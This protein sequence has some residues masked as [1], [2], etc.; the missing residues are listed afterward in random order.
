MKSV[1]KHDFGQTANIEMQRSSFDRSHG[2]KTAFDAG[3][4]I[5]FYLDEILPG[6][7]VNLKTTALARI[8][9]PYFP[10][11]DNIFMETQ[12]F[13]VPNRLI[14]DNFQK[15][16]GEQTNPG[17]S[18]DYL[19]PRLQAPPVGG[20]LEESVFD[21]MG[22][23]PGVDN[24]QPNALHLRA[25]NLIWNQWY[26]D[27]NLQDS[28][29]VFTG[30]GPDPTTSYEILPRGKRPDYFTSALPWPQKGDAVD[31]PLGT[32]API[33]GTGVPTF[34]VST[35]TN[36]PLDANAGDAQFS[37]TILSG[38]A[39]WN[40]PQ[41]S[42]DLSTATAATINELRQAFQIQRLLERDARGG[43]RYTEIV[44]SHFGVTSP[45]ARLQRAEYL[46]GGRATINFQSVPI[47]EKLSAGGN[48]A[49]DLS[50]YGQTMLQD[51]G[52][53]KSFT[54]HGVLIGFVS[55]RADLTYQ[56][57]LDRMW[58]RQSKYDFYFP[59]LSHIGEQAILNKEIYLRGTGGDDNVF[60]YIP[61]YDEYRFKNSQ[62]TGAMRSSAT[63]SLDPWHLSQD[64]GALPVLGDTF[65]QED[66]PIDR[67][68]TVPTE[69]Q[70]IFDS[71][72]SARFARPLPTYGT[73]G[74]LDRF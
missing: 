52:F 59:A 11:M 5:P 15:F 16:M 44:R 40:D 54:E 12:Y 65:I 56:Q 39:S 41:L 66:P 74:M 26:R 57:G 55:V 8:S 22:I 42:A 71:Y 45:D 3:K 64:F 58:S 36:L 37:G 2:Y 17:D 50:A 29:D 63:A 28:K 4:L 20:F 70:F 18:T 7:S 6:D 32:T 23:P 34:D 30:D 49:G 47:S 14:W 13:F 38:N 21:Y 43:T 31:L 68:V 46:G 60:G 24:I 72:I 51:N 69:P 53:T 62:V 73:P 33:T 9:T 35:D 1:M 19:V 67:V 27:E 10:I 61:R 48:N 25:M